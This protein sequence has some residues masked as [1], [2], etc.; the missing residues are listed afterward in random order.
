MIVLLGL[1]LL[2]FNLKKIILIIG[3]FKPEVNLLIKKFKKNKIFFIENQL[4]VAIVGVGL[5]EASLNLENLISIYKN[6]KIEIEEIIF[7]G[8]AGVYAV[9]EN[10]NNF[11]INVNESKI[12]NKLNLSKKELL[13]KPNKNLEL[14]YGLNQF[15]FSKSFSFFDLAYIHGEAHKPKIF[16]NY[17]ATDSG[18]FTKFLIKKMKLINDKSFFNLN[19]NKI[20]TNTTPYVTIKSLNKVLVNKFQKKEKKFIITKS[21]ENLEAYGL[22][23]VAKRNKIKFSSFLALTNQIGNSSSKDWFKNY[24]VMSE[25]LQ[26]II[27]KAI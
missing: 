19:E 16:S 18:T 14:H 13:L 24:K 12:K 10:E 7:L 27:I 8:S 26:N 25:K 21:I 4:E 20:L 22:A 11:N 5:L 1:Y 23:V 3:A 2:L 15:A 17:I 9:N 6:N